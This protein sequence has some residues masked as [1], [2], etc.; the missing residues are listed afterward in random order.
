VV[1]AP[2]IWWPWSTS[3][4][5]GHRSNAPRMADSERPRVAQGDLQ[6]LVYLEKRVLI[7]ELRDPNTQRGAS[8]TVATVP[9]K[10]DWKL[11]IEWRV[12]ST[13]A[14]DRKGRLWSPGTARWLAA[15]SW[16]AV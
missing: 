16:P 9:S 14:P 11:I 7:V 3:G 5:A 2:V 6:I 10:D 13:E 1:T 12:T 15:F 8:S 4:S